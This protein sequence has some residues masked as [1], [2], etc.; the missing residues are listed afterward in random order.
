M[1]MDGIALLNLC[2][3]NENHNKILYILV[4]SSVLECVI[5]KGMVYSN[6]QYHYSVAVNKLL[7]YLISNKESYA[8]GENAKATFTT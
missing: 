8:V 4:H 1:Y 5:Q 2:N 6:S 7:L 3:I